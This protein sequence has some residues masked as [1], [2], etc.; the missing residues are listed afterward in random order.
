LQSPP[1]VHAIHFVFGGSE[2][3]FEQ[4][5]A[6]RWLHWRD[7]QCSRVDGCEAWK[8]NERNW[9]KD[10]LANRNGASVNIHYVRFCERSS[11]WDTD[12]DREVSLGRDFAIVLVVMLVDGITGKQERLATNI[13]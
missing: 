10:G 7:R 11:R 1:H 12:K 5:V 13:D 4:S 3:C 8:R 9:L 6:G 2:M